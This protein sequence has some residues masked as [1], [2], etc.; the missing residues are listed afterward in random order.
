MSTPSQKVTATLELQGGRLARDQRRAEAARVD[1]P[2][3]NETPGRIQP[4]LPNLKWRR[5]PTATVV[6]FMPASEN[7]TRAPALAPRVVGGESQRR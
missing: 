7:V 3:L 6:V 2:A 5:G 4:V 1:A